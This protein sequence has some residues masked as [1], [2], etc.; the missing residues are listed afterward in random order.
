MRTIHAH[1]PPESHPPDEPSALADG[2]QV[3]EPVP[4]SIQAPEEEEEEEEEE[5]LAE[6]LT[7]MAEVNLAVKLSA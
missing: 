5:A 4:I 3:Y 1:F 7:L 6:G 2:L